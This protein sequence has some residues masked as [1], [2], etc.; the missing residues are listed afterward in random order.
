LLDPGHNSFWFLEE[1]WVL[2]AVDETAPLWSKSPNGVSTKLN[3]NGQTRSEQSTPEKLGSHVHASFAPQE[4]CPE[5]E[6]GHKAA[7]EATKANTAKTT[8][9]VGMKRMNM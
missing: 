2:T 4:P 5:Q 9:I 3:P 1:N 7:A 6:L 8:F